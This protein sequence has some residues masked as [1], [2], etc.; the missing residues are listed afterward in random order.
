[1]KL[2]SE[3]IKLPQE[4]RLYQLPVPILG[5]TGG[6]SSGKTTVSTIMAQNGLAIINADSLV[7]EI[8][9]WPETIQ[10]IKKNF[11]EAII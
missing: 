5:L 7:K 9:S 4:K 2:K 1:M 6:I 11:P 3:F 8:Y 10:F